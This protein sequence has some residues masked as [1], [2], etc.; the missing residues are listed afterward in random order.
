MI[1]LCFHLCSFTSW[2]RSLRCKFM[3]FNPPPPNPPLP[4]VYLVCILLL[5]FFYPYHIIAFFGGYLW[6]QAGR[7]SQ[8]DLWAAAVCRRCKTVDCWDFSRRKK[9]VVLLDIWIL[10]T[11]D[12]YYY[13]HYPPKKTLVNIFQNYVQNFNWK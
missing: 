13:C 6:H 7:F 11:V 10:H 1:S 5:F 9:N 8:E 2:C 12:Q 3:G 4:V